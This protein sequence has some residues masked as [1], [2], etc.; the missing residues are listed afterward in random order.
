MPPLSIRALGWRCAW[1]W[2]VSLFLVVGG[3]DPPVPP[4]A[5]QPSRNARNL[6]QG[7][8]RNTRPDLTDRSSDP[9]LAPPLVARL[10]VC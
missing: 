9:T 6:K 8:G 5:A 10:M 3:V 7:A 1:S 4:L 2:V